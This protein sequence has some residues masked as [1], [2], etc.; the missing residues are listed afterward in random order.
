LI[1]TQLPTSTPDMIG[2]SSLSLNSVSTQLQQSPQMLTST[3]SLDL[4]PKISKWRPLKL[5]GTLKIKANGDFVA[6]INHK[7]THFCI[8]DYQSSDAV[9]QA[10]N[11][12]LEDESKSKCTNFYMIIDELIYIDISLELNSSIIVIIDID[13]FN[14][15]QGLVWRNR[16]KRVFTVSNGTRHYLEEK[17]YPGKKITQYLDG[18][19]LNYSRKNILLE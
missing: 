13:K 11:T 4:V 8:K 14:D 19:Y 12:F 15:V 10:A 7:H 5:Y 18:N 1:T 6:R 3:T 17:L 9:R 16:N 2:S